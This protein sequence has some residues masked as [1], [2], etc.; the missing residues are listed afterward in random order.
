M[1]I[2]LIIAGIIIFIFI[3]GGMSNNRPVEDW[4]DEKLIRMLPKLQHA[5]STAM[6]VSNHEQAKGQDD[7][8]K[9]VEAEIGRRV[10]SVINRNKD[11]PLK[12]ISMNLMSQGKSEQAAMV[13]QLMSNKTN[14]KLA[15]IQSSK[16]CSREEAN[17]I[18]S[19]MIMEEQQELFQSGVSEDFSGEM[20]YRKIVGLG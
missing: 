5:R 17:T 10:E 3:I 11:K 18:M 12:E 6:N 9:E 4:T 8:I 2:A 20:A 15:E 7:K 16:N 19:E 14:E 1:E 13:A